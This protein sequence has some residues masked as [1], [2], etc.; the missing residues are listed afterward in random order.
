M[1]SIK[2]YYKNLFAC[3]YAYDNRSNITTSFHRA[4]YVPK[5]Q[6]CIHISI[7]CGLIN[8]YTHKHGVQLDIETLFFHR[9]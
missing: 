4:T 7:S 5:T 2:N 8:E 9:T 3:K 1:I 6:M